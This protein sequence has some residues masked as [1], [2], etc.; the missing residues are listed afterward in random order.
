MIQQWVNEN[1]QTLILNIIKS[2]R[3]LILGRRKNI[4]AIEEFFHKLFGKEV[5][6]LP[7]GRSAI[8]QYA[9]SSGYSRDHTAFITKYSSYCMYQSLGT[10]MNISTD[11]QKPELLVINHKW[12]Y[13]NIDPRTSQV[14]ST[15][16]DS[17]DSLV[18]SRAALFPNG[19]HIEVISLG[20][21]SGGLVIFNNPTS[22]SKN[23]TH[24]QNKNKFLGNIQF[25]R[26]LLRILFPHRFR[27]ALP[28]EYANTFLTGIELAMIRKS[29]PNYLSN[30]NFNS[31]R[32]LQLITCF[33]QNRSE[34]KRVGPGMVLKFR[35]DLQTFTDLNIPK[36][37]LIRNFD[38]STSNDFQASY[39]ICLY[40]PIHRGVTE[41]TFKSYLEFIQKYKHLL[42]IQ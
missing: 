33:G 28:F 22:I 21:L 3:Y 7:S 16:E 20:T 9:R 42:S 18:I 14:R 40:V 11:F 1:T 38:Y 31:F 2:S 39:Q 29:M 15:I 5:I 23:L 24:L 8:Y 10:L 19:G 41:Q 35:G 37:I 25:I 30:F 26:K 34:L 17:C 27:L 36:G 13:V 6:L 12:G 32:Y 4:R